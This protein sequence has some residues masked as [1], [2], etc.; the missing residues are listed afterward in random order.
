M[1]SETI[2]I[3]HEATKRDAA[4]ALP[5]GLTDRS[6]IAVGDVDQIF[7]DLQIKK[8]ASILKLE[9]LGDD[10]RFAQ[11]V[12]QDV[13]LFIEAKGL[14][15]NAK[16][17][18]AIA[19]LYR[20][21]A[22]A[23]GDDRA[24]GS[25]ARAVDALASDVRHWLVRCDPEGRDVPTAAKIVSTTTRA[26]AV[27]Q[28]RLVLSYGCFKRKGRKR[29]TGRRSQSYEPLLW[30][31]GKIEPNRPRS[32]AEREFVRNLGLTYSDATGKRPPYKVDF[33]A[34]GPFSEFVHECFEAAGAP[35]GSVTRLINELGR[36]RRAEASRKIEH[37]EDAGA[38][39]ERDE[40]FRQGVA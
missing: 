33:D 39:L 40:W 13:R 15:N 28:L 4:T 5:R 7:N 26:S 17:R 8:L 9:A 1:K 20:L 23:E 37:R 36:A 21:N 24:A 18:K 34:R 10:P 16:L 12:R 32:E 22:R 38:H 6:L 30:V 2:P 35:P 25:L 19:R 11:S 29:P 14:L 3:Q 31:P 27:Q